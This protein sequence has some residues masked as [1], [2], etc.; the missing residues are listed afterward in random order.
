LLAEHGLSEASRRQPALLSGLNVFQGKL[1]CRAVAQAH[2]LPW[3]A[4]AL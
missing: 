4:P 3:E 1:T 2:G